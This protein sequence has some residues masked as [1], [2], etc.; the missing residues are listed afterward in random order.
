MKTDDG[1]ENGKTETPLPGEEDAEPELPEAPPE[2]QEIPSV[3]E[4]GETEAPLP[5]EEETEPVQPEAPPEEPEA[6]EYFLLETR[7]GA[8]IVVFGAPVE[9]SEPIITPF[10]VGSRPCAFH[11]CSNTV[12]VHTKY[13][14]VCDAHKCSVSGCSS[15]LYYQNPNKCQVH[16][17]LTNIICQIYMPENPD[18]LCGKP[19]V[20][21]GAICCW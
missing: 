13:D 16:A 2:D 15:P 6:P 14:F 10:L 11:E 5:G 18:G 17:G 3:P 8:A 21:N 20:G 19:S 7:S 4:N 9:P 1:L 12:T